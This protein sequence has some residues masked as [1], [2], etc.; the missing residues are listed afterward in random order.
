MASQADKRLTHRAKAVKDAA[1]STTAKMV[2]ARG[3]ITPV[4]SGRLFVR[5]MMA[6]MSR[7][8]TM[9]KVFA[10]PAA[11]VPPTNVATISQN[12]GIPFAATTMVGM[13]VT[14]NNSMMRGL[15]R[16]T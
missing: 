15:V 9:L 16:A 13:V 3:V 1:S 7:S 10:P 14:S 2:A 4:T 6:S 11:R 12:P 5:S 8:S